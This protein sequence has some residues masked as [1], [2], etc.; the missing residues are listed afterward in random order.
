MSALTRQRVDLGERSYDIIVGSG[1]LA[2]AHEWIMPVL[3]GPRAVIISD[4]NVAPLY[5]AALQANLRAQGVACELLVVPAGEG[6]KSF[7]GF[8]QLIEQLLAL[9]PD[10]K[11]TLIALG[12]G[13]VGDLVGFAASVL[14]RGVPFIQV[15]TSLLAQVDSSVGGKTAI[16]A[17][18][19]KNLIGSFYQPK[20]VL[21]DSDVLA[22]LPAREMRA[23]YAEIIKYGLIMDKG[24]YRWCLGQGAVLLAGNTEAIQH[25]VRESCRMKAAI[26]AEDECEA[27]RRALLNFGHTFAHALEAETGFGEKLLHGEA[28]GI[29]MVMAC[30]LSQRLGLIDATA[31]A[32]L[33]AH[34]RSLKLLAVPNDVAH[35]WDA[36]AIARH[37]SADKKAEN[38]TLT[39]VVLDAVGQ[40][41]VAKNVDAMLAL[42]VVA[43]CL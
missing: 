9:Q 43:S 4:A 22:T 5:A 34:L 25:A 14:L 8:E 20:L 21:A 26:V 40:A 36:A 2:R 12:G 16:N 24:F 33:A 32:E 35:D 29:G 42:D 38:G 15:P 30:R 6:S 31:G 41:R 37:F 1:L 17:T 23:G 10:R 19:G 39:F 3:A 11:T 27:D 7:A 18:T 28:V 13:V